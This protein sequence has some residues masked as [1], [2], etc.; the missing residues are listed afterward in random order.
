MW[1][2]AEKKRLPGGKVEGLCSEQGFVQQAPPLTQPHSTALKIPCRSASQGNFWKFC[3][4]DFDPSQIIT[5]QSR[6]T[7]TKEENDCAFSPCSR[8]SRMVIN[9]LCS[10]NKPAKGGITSTAV[11]FFYAMPKLQKR[12]HN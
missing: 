2:V 11:L 10:A 6:S 1:K 8:I 3:I 5:T 9:V 12:G 7:H 4:F